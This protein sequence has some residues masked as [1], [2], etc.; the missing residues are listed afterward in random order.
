MYNNTILSYEQTNSKWH[1]PCKQNSQKLSYLRQLEFGDNT[2][3]ILHETASIF[4]RGIKSLLNALVIIQRKPFI[5]T[6]RDRTK[7]LR[8]QLCACV[9]CVHKLCKCSILST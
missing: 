4:M 9:A 3:I 5:Y 8:K 7:Y 6:C 2:V 1:A